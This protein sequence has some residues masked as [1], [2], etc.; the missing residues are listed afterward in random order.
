M[1]A[2]WCRSKFDTSKSNQKFLSEYRS[3]LNL[4]KKFKITVC[5]LHLSFPLSFCRFT[6]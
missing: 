6:T 2:T 3:F 4:P 5:K 1:N